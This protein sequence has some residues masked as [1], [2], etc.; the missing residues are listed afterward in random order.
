MVTKKGWT[1]PGDALKSY[2]GLEKLIP[3]DK[4]LS[5]PPS[6]PAAL[7]QW[8]G[9]AKLGVPDKPEAYELKRP[10]SLPEGMVY[11]AE[12]ETAA[13]ALAVEAKLTPWQLQKMLDGFH[14]LQVTRY[15]GL[16]GQKAATKAKLEA[17]LKAE[18]GAKYDDNIALARRVMATLSPAEQQGVDAFESIKGAP[19]VLRMFSKLGAMIAEDRLANPQGGSG[20]PANA[21]AEIER[22]KSDPNFVKALQNKRDPGHEA[23]KRQWDKAHGIAA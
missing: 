16:D 10:E 12:L 6:D 7:P 2:Q 14:A 11:D 5:V 8:E 4:R 17:D 15:T 21:A 3:A 13:K 9:W 18:W 20:A 1:G 22:L 23:A 19:E